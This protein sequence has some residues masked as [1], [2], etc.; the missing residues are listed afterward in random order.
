ML[1]LGIDQHACQITICL[2]NQAGDVV[3]SRQVST[4]PEK[5]Q[6]FFTQLKRECFCEAERLITV[7]DQIQI[8]CSGNRTGE[9]RSGIRFQGSD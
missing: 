1:H 2:R 5:V 8:N 3:Q 4:R 9:G 6:E 7:L